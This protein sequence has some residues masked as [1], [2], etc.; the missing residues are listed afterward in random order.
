MKVMTAVLTTMVFVL[1]FGLAYADGVIT[2]V[3]EAGTVLYDSAFHVGTIGMDHKDFARI[4]NPAD[5]M[6]EVGAVVN[7]RTFAKDEGMLD[8]EARG[9]AAGGTSRDSELDK[10]WDKA[11]GPGGSDLP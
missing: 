3:K 6:Y 7:N 4:P 1:A 5:E 10:I 2:E 8:S 9:A 11:L